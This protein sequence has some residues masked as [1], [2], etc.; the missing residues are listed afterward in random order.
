MVAVF[1]ALVRG[2]VAGSGGDVSPMMIGQVRAAHPL[3]P[4]SARSMTVL[5]IGDRRLGGIVA[6]YPTHHTP[7]DRLPVVFAEFA[8]PGARRPAAA[9]HRRRR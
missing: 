4:F 8:Y 7:P 5:A 9:G 2:A 1:A 3:L 6:D